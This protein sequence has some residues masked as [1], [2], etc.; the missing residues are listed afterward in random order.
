MMK[1]LAIMW[2]SL[3][4]ECKKHYEEIACTDKERC[5]FAAHSSG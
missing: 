5:E 4:A 2:N 1:Q 3:P